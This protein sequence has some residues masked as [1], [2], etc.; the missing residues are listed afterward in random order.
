MG[1]TLV[2]SLPP[3]Y[4]LTEEVAP[5]QTCT[6]PAT[7]VEPEQ[8][9]RAARTRCCPLS[10]R[11]PACSPQAPSKPSPCAPAPGPRPRAPAQIN[12]ITNSAKDS[13]R[14]ELESGEGGG[15]VVNEQDIAN[16]VAQWTG[17][18]IE[19][20]GGW[21]GGG[22]VEGDRAAWPSRALCLGCHSKALCMGPMEAFS[23][24]SWMGRPALRCVVRGS[25]GR[26]LA[27][28]AS[29][30]PAALDPRLALRSPLSPCPGLL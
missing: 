9:H 27:P 19:K 28:P 18:P 10:L 15:P 5:L 14:A 24:G 16:I 29:V 2:S 1:A 4:Y 23:W 25:P 17:I 8:Q 20:V 11:L 22:R 13:A 26:H 21:A 3:P 7:P 6:A 12:A 30:P